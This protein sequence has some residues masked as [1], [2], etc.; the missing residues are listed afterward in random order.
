MGSKLWWGGTGIQ[1][2]RSVTITLR[3]PPQKI[4]YN[5]FSKAIVF[6]KNNDDLGLLFYLF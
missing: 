1:R 5:F 6:I 2:V 4:F 3:G